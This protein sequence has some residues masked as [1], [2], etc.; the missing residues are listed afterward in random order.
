MSS[1]DTM[2]DLMSLNNKCSRETNRNNKTI[3][4]LQESR[5]PVKEGKWNKTLDTDIAKRLRNA[6]DEENLRD[7]LDALKDGYYWIAQ[8][9]DYSYDET[10]VESD[11]EDFDYI[12]DNEEAV[13]Y[14]LDKFYDVCDALRIWVPTHFEEAC[15]KKEVS[16]KDS[17]KDKKDKVVTEDT[18]G[19]NTDNIKTYPYKVKEWYHKEYPDDDIWEEIDPD[20][21]FFDVYSTLRGKHDVYDVLGVGDSVVRERVFDK[22][23][24]IGKVDY[25]VIYN[26]W[27]GE[28]K[29]SSKA[30]KKLSEKVDPEALAELN[31]E[32]EKKLANVKSLANLSVDEL[33]QLRAD[34]V[35]GSIYLDDYE[36][37]FGIDPDY[38]YATFEGYADYLGELMQDEIPGYDDSKFYDYL[39]EY[40]TPDHMD[41]YF[42][43]MVEWSDD[44]IKAMT[45]Q[46]RDDIEDWYQDE[47]YMA[48][49]GEDSLDESKK[50]IAKTEAK[51]KNVKHV[52]TIDEQ[53]LDILGATLLTVEEA[54]Q[55][56]KRLREYYTWWWL[57][58]PG[59]YSYY[60]AYVYANGFV[61]NYG[62][63]VSD[64]YGSVRPALIISNLESSGLEI[65]DTFEFGKKRFEIISNDRAFCL[66]GEG[67][68]AFRYD[69]KA[70]DANDYEKSDIKKDVD[71][72]FDDHKGEEIKIEAKK[73]VKEGV[74]YAV[75]RDEEDNDWGLGSYS[76]AKAKQIAKKNGYK[77]IAKI[78]DGNDP[79]CDGVYRLDDEGYWIFEQ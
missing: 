59:Y 75:Q 52:A 76:F 25:D 49:D 50:R 42:N 72:W 16:K 57:K 1:F 27:L 47:L 45:K 32:K 73:R 9:D 15:G 69:W 35:M 24:E 12:D 71:E 61:Y 78:L 43:Y 79:V 28:S 41:E 74:W 21:T 40:D 37:R 44:D 65:G 30:T 13:N 63:D 46:A 4:K 66:T 6:I 36:N 55:L 64:E 38:V 17:K 53:D 19:V 22:L 51:I 5:K 54:K 33:K 39:D 29:K 31:A 7:V 14:E 2:F 77:I 68:C 11:I 26:M 60:A 23:S 48:D 58:S 34:V 70:S 8:Q 18:H 67:P 20:I 10:D 62:T 3:K 56:P